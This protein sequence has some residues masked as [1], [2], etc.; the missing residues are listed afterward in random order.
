MNICFHIGY[1]KTGT[2]WL[3]RC[4]FEPHPRIHLINDARQPW[5]DPVIRYLVATREGTF[6]PDK[7]RELIGR[8][9]VDVPDG[10]VAMFSAERLSGHPYSG[11]FDSFRI[12]S[13]ISA[14][15]PDAKILIIIRDQVEMIKSMYKE[16]VAEGYPGRVRDLFRTDHWR[17]AAFDLAFYEYDLLINH[18]LK[19]FSAG[20]VNV[21]RYEDLRAEP[22]MFLENVSRFLGAGDFAESDTDNR[23]NVSLRNG[24]VPVARFLNR[25]RRSEMNPFPLFNLPETLRRAI[26]RAARVVTRD[27]ALLSKQEEI[28]IRDRFFDSN[29]RLDSTVVRSGL[30]AS[31]IHY[32]SSDK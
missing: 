5:N 17:A 1:H 8:A 19:H 29:S 25:F 31:P 23:V 4:Y 18:Y 30:T 13:R 16:L 9:A 26:V 2:S 27:T 6:D 12:A 15:V 22:L 28:E 32:G 3:Q 7:C 20:S 24:V 11:G 14:S 10:E 21:Q